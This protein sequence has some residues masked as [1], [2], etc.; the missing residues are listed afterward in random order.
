MS[1]KG[2][3]AHNGVRI[4]GIGKAKDRIDSSQ[5]KVHQAG[6][7]SERCWRETKEFWFY[8]ASDTDCVLWN[9]SCGRDVRHTGSSTAICKCRVLAQVAAF[10]L[11]LPSA[12][13][14]Q[15]VVLLS[16]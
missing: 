8:G 11:S 12:E 5:D 16:A 7:A 15:L 1:E 14:P 10:S 9:K 6:D 13:S 2:T 3:S 4:V